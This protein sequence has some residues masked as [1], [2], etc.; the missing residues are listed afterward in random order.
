MTTAAE[1]ARFGLQGYARPSRRGPDQIRTM[2]VATQSGNYQ[3][4]CFWSYAAATITSHNFI[5]MMALV[6]QH[7]GITLHF[8]V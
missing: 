2:R 1:I 4:R 8:G 3:A 6:G 7:T 5:P